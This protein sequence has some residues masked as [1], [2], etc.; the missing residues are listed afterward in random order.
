MSAHHESNGRVLVIEDSDILGMLFREYL[1]DAN[2]DVTLVTTGEEGLGTLNESSFE[3]VILDLTL[4]GIHGFDVLRMI[5]E[6]DLPVSTIVA[7]ASDTA[8][9][10]LEA[11][12]LGAADFLAKPVD[13]NRLLVTVSNV[14]KQHRL[15][16]IVD[17]YQKQLERDHFEGLIG[18]SAVM[19]GVYRIIETA[20]P[21]QASIFITGE[22]GTGKELCAE[23]IH[24][25]SARSDG[26][27]ITINCA[28][29]PRDLMESEIFGH[30]KGAFTGAHTEREG[31]ATLA[32]GGTL[33][34]DELCEM[35]LDLQSKL[36]RFIQTGTFQRVGSGVTKTVDIRFVCAT[37][38]DPL[39][40][41]KAGRF[42][43]DLFYRL[44]VIPLR[45]PPLRERGSD[46]RLISRRMLVDV[47]RRNGKQFESFAPEVEQL[48]LNYPWPGNVRELENTIVNMVVMGSGETATRQMVPEYLTCGLERT[49]PGPAPSFL[50]SCS[51]VIQVPDEDR[52]PDRQKRHIRPLWLEEK[53]LIEQAIEICNGNIPRAAA[54]LEVSASTIYRKRVSWEE[55]G[56]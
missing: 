47:S 27:L 23:A 8:E 19:Q 10:A 9:T 55:S 46:I 31:A 1:Q 15:A 48:F 14:L 7:T 34:L 24:R 30:V 56:Q 11:I 13:A 26:P 49:L 5:Q 33:F 6:K 43:E 53:E 44:H 3:L 54:L 29:I 50:Q 40:E 36:L 32:D 20:A 21:S 2:Y 35:D 22:S 42:R 51:A 28:A 45:L 16:N 39:A 12:K 17:H 4:P 52:G 41:V 25:K 18:S 37:N 38:R